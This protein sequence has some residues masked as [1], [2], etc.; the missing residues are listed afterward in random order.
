MTGGCDSIS[1]GRGL[2]HPKWFFW[3]DRSARI[4]ATQQDVVHRRKITMKIAPPWKRDKTVHVR[5]YTRFR[6]GR[7]ESV[8]SHWRRWPQQLMLPL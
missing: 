7:H 8:C 1:V 5:A 3:F 2:V 6:L 4:E